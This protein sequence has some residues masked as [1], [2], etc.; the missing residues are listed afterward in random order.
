MDEALIQDL[1]VVKLT[2]YRLEVEPLP[3]GPAIEEWPI[4]SPIEA[5]RS[6]ARRMGALAS[7][8]PHR[9]CWLISTGPRA[10]A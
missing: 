7:W 9:C 1:R 6:R 2:E 4:D 3:L 10:V 8:C 5:I